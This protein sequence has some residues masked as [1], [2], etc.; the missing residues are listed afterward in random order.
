MKAFL[1]GYYELL[2]MGFDYEE[3]LIEEIKSVTKEE[4][5]N[6][7]KKYFSTSGALCVLAPEKD[8]KA[9]KLC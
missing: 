5:I 8:L 3:K 6:T 1:K 9:A 7:A 4:I 2:K